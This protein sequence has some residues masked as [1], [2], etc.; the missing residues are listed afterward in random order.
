MHSRLRAVDPTLNTREVILCESPGQLFPLLSV[1]FLA[2]PVFA[3][4]AG[5]GPVIWHDRGD[6][7]VLDLVDGS[8]G[9]DH[10]PGTNFKFIK[11]SSER[12]F[13]Q[14]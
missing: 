8:G 9:K 5:S 6:V 13:A 4:Q 10:E 11:E 1:L 12:N 7:S 2:L 3:Q 14:V